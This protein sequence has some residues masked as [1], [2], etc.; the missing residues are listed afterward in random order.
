MSTPARQ[1]SEAP[2]PHAGEYARRRFAHLAMTPEA[3]A[4]EDLD[5]A[6]PL[7]PEEQ[8][9]FLRD[10]ATWATPDMI[11]RFKADFERM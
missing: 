6:P 5:L 11:A 2:A 8:A 4:A 7:S 10:A 3:L 1:S 9:A